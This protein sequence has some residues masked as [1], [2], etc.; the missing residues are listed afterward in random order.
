ME[1]STS[2]NAISTFDKIKILGIDT[3]KIVKDCDNKP[4]RIKA[5]VEKIERLMGLVLKYKNGV[6]PLEIR[7]II[8]KYVT[9]CRIEKFLKEDEA[10][11]VLVPSDTERALLWEKHKTYARIKRELKKK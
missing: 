4:G 9:A 8:G 6:N 10:L 5:R 1:N 11:K 3:E 7:G 2:V